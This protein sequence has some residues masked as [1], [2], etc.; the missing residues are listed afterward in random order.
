MKKQIKEKTS[1]RL[2]L[3]SKINYQPLYYNR[4]LAHVGDLVKYHNLI[5][6]AQRFDH[7]H[8]VTEEVFLLAGISEEM[9]GIK[10]D[11]EDPM[12]P[13]E[14]LQWLADIRNNRNSH[15]VNLSYLVKA[16]GA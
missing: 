15:I 7:D 11:T 3:N 10:Q 8:N 9:M 12:H 13:A 4:E 2:D 14:D 16:K 6:V 1:S 5:D